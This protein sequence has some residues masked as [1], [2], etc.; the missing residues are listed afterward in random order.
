MRKSVIHTDPKMKEIAKILRKNSTL[1]EMMLWK[2]LRGKKMLGYEFQR[3]VPI[4]KYIVD[5][6]CPALHLAIEIDGV[7]HIS[8]DIYRTDRER[9]ATLG[10]TDLHFLRF[11]DDTVRNDMKSVLVEISMWIKEHSKRKKIMQNPPAARSQ[12]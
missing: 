9:D 2:E 11:T 4:G 8:D 6:Y 5:F 10:K 7:T 12:Q 3:E 1:G